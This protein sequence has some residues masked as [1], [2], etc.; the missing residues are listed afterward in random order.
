MAALTA[1]R[2]RVRLG[3]RHGDS[4]DLAVD[5]ALH[6]VRLVRRLRIVGVAQLDVV[7]VGCGLGALADQIPERVARHLV[8]DHRDRGARRVRLCQHPSPAVLSGL[9]PVHEHDAIP[10]T[11]TLAPAIAA[12][13]LNLISPPLLS[14]AT[15]HA[16]RLDVIRLTPESQYFVLTLGLHVICSN[17]FDAG[18]TVG[19]AV[20]PRTIKVGSRVMSTAAA[21]RRRHRRAAPPAAAPPPA[22]GR[23][24]PG[25]SS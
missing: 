11:S 13:R 18:Q 21:V 10:T 17:A 24:S 6:Q 8:G 7:L 1:G 19:G 15:W 9:P 2:H 20:E 22:R 3:Q 5:R 14:S 25:E 16:S 4:V 12:S 23:R